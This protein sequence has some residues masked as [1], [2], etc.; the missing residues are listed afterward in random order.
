MKK[1]PTNQSTYDVAA[2]LTTTEL[3]FLPNSY[4]RAAGYISKITPGFYVLCACVLLIFCTPYPSGADEP[5]LQVALISF[6]GNRSFSDSRLKGLMKTREKGL[7]GIFEKAYYDEE[8]FES[9]LKRIEDFY[10]SEGFYDVQVSKGEVKQIGPKLIR[11]TVKVHEG[12]PVR[13]SSIDL[14]VNGEKNTSWH[15]E[16]LKL[17]PLKKGQRFRIEDFDKT[18]KNILKYLA[19]WGYPK[20]QVKRKARIF[21]QSLQARV[22]ISVETG[23]PCTFGTLRIEGLNRV[24]P[25][26]IW[27]NLQFKPGERFSARKIQNSQRKLYDTQLFTYVDIRVEGLDTE[28]TELPVVITVVEARP[29]TVRAGVGYGTEEQLR[30]KL[31]LEARRFLGDGRTLRGLLKGS[32]IEQLAELQFYQPHFPGKD[33]SIEWNT[34][35]DHEDQESYTVNTF[36]SRPRFNVKIS[37]K[38]SWYAGHNLE[39]NDLTGVDIAPDTD[40]LLDRQKDNYFISSIVSGFTGRYVDDILDPNR[41]FQIF[42]STE[43][44]SSLTGSDVAF[45]KTTWEGRAYIPLSSFVLA[46]RA[47]WGTIVNLENDQKIP[48]FKRFFAGGSNSVRGYPYQKLGPLDS[49]GNPLGGS[50]VLEANVDLRFPLKIKG[51]SF[52]GVLFFDMGQ[53][54][55]GQ[56]SLDPTDLRYTIG[57]GLRYQTPIGPIRVDLGYQLNPPDQDFF[58]PLQI[59]FSIGQAF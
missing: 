28:E 32:F 35:W 48:I 36:Y 49:E 56:L 38:W 4:K 16:L 18:E 2:L 24:N 40:D 3:E 30:G 8:I 39:F 45:I 1:G 5:R 6:I 46:L 19:D 31:E 53:V 51:R 7:L 44:A 17:I 15:D 13:I 37:N 27:L 10:R 57:A 42:S 41:G 14:T 47:R 54:Y 23:P 21:K 43:W 55:P 11:L 25:K 29:Y 22:S 34:G 12:E 33:Q 52:Q 9:D 58:G 59:Y 50:S 20:A 26:E